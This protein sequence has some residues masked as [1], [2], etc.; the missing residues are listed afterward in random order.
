MIVTDSVI[1]K[2]PSPLR[3]AVAVAVAELPL[4]LLEELII[5]QLL[6]VEVW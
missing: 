2:F 1:S 4:Q 5:V 6:L 3:L